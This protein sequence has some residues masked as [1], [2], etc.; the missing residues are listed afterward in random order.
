M[1]TPHVH[2]MPFPCHHASPRAGGGAGQ[3]KWRRTC[4]TDLACFLVEARRLDS[5]EAGG[6]VLHRAQVVDAVRDDGA[7]GGTPDEADLVLQWRHAQL[8]Q[9]AEA[10]AREVGWQEA[11]AQWGGDGERARG[12]RPP[13]L[14]PRWKAEGVGAPQ[15]GR[16][17]PR[18][19]EAAL[20]FR[21]IGLDA[22]EQLTKGWVGGGGKVGNEGLGRWAINGSRWA[23]GKEAPR[24]RRAGCGREE[25]IS[26]S[27]AQGGGRSHEEAGAKPTRASGSPCEP[28]EQAR[29]AN[30]A[31]ASPVTVTALPAK[32]AAARRDTAEPQSAAA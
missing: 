13:A 22:C 26:A 24:K 32:V 7:V 28:C 3:F 1:Y 25:D 18:E 21:L 27:A 8:A 29:G 2:C 4:D 5:R 6:R 14:H 20:L 17:T 15:A 11:A 31:L 23:G 9:V 16:C 10:Y 19:D 12:D 30:S